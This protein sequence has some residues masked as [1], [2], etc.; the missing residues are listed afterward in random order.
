MFDIRASD[1][2][3]G[4]RGWTYRQFLFS[5]DD[6]ERL[7][8]PLRQVHAGAPPFFVSYGSDDFPHVIRTGEAMV[9]AL[10]AAKVP[11]LQRVYAGV[12]HY[13]ANL[14]MGDPSH[15]WVRTVRH[16]LASGKAPE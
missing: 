14:D 7:A 3:P 1:P 9:T 5:K 12:D 10:R 8:S 6:D 2:A 16:W 4:N 15:D 13:Q 11:V